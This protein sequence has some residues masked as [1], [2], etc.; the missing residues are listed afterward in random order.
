MAQIFY[1]ACPTCRERF[2]CHPELWQA[3][4]DL[5]CPFCGQMFPQEASP[6]ITTGTGEQRPG[7][8]AGTWSAAGGSSEPSGTPRIPTIDAEGSAESM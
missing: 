2:P 8:S 4:Y 7:R 3:E 1:V 6:M 5:L